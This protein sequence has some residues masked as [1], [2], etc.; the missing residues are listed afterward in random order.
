MNEIFSADEKARLV[1]EQEER[2][3][4]NELA[5]LKR[6]KEKYESN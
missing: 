3:R 2:I 4:Q 1:K 6:L 5:E